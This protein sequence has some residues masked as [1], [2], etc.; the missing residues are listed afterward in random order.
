MD[1]ALLH[2]ARDYALTGN[3][4][5][6]IVR[7]G[8]IVLTWGDLQKKYD[9]KSTTKSVGV[10]ALGLALKDGHVQLDHRAAPLHPS[11]GVP[12]ESNRETQWL[13]DI[14]LLHLATHTAGFEKPGGY[15]PLLF[16][17]GTAWHYS[18]G[19][20]NWLAECLTLVYEKD[21]EHLLF[22]RVFNPIGITSDD[23]HWRENAYRPHEIQGMKRREFGSGAHANVDAMARIGLLYLHQGNWNGRQLIPENFVKTASTTPDWMVGLPEHD[24]GHHGNA[25]DH[26]GLLWWNNNDGTLQEVP[27]DAF[28][29]WGLY[30]SL[31][32]VIPSLDLVVSRAGKSW[33]R[34]WDGHYDVLKPFLEPIVASVKDS[35]EQSLSTAR[36]RAVAGAPYPGSRFIRSIRWAP[37]NEIL[38]WAEGSDNWPVTWAEDGHLYTAYGDGWGFEPKVPEKLSLGFARVEG[39]PP[40][41]KGFNI[42]SPSG[43]QKGQGPNGKK[44]SGMLM[45]DGVLHMW[46]RNAGNS[47]LAWSRDLAKTWSW[48]DW[49]FEESFGAPTFLNFGRNYQGARDNYIYVYSHDSDSAYEAADRM[50][51]ARVPKTQLRQ[52]KAYQFFVK[53]N[54]KGQPVWSDNIRDRGAVF[55]HPNK[56]YRNGIT[57]HPVHDRYLWCQ[58]LPQSEDSRGPRF[59]GGFGVYEAPEPW[60]P[61]STLFYTENWDVGPG[62]TSSLP[63]KWMSRDGYRVFLLFSGDDHFSVREGFL[64]LNAP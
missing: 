29:S 58:V 60:G 1:S 8:E 34:N 64:Q 23:L 56:C 61:W 54:S 26:Y 38:R 32:V 20:P 11:L 6:M 3:G 62:E 17:P 25:S 39:S 27:R 14:T 37:E 22:E 31:I 15:E 18:D 16:P 9:L 35:S 59:Q 49:K 21:L 41:L 42:R 24:T 43:E 48:S 4:S 10:T 52:R 12:P 7:H 30:D 45:V 51:L 63:V 2:K 40:D 44:A 33:E 57:H 36:N 53:L 5:G 47:Q 19:G 55:E 46:V 13:D 28:W 50:V